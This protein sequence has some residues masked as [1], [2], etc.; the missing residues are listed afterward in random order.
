MDARGCRPPG[1]REEE[2]RDGRRN[3]AL[4]TRSNTPQQVFRLQISCDSSLEYLSPWNRQFVTERTETRH[5]HTEGCW[6]SKTSLTGR[7][8]PPGRPFP[9]RAQL[10]WPA[11]RPAVCV[12]RSGG[13]RPAGSAWLSTNRAS[14]VATSASEWI[15]N[16]LSTNPRCHLLN[17]KT[18]RA[19]DVGSLALAATQHRMILFVWRSLFVWRC[20]SSVSAEY[21]HER[22]GHLQTLRNGAERMCSKALTDLPGRAALGAHRAQAQGIVTLGE[23]DAVFI[24]HQRA[25]IKRR[26]RK[27]ERTIEQELAESGQQ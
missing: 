4:L 10:C 2:P 26:R 11:E 18:C 9:R 17:D 27:A 8:G 12:R 21:R 19:A 23:P 6:I 15:C 16:R 24:G 14:V 20:M 25:M 5:E 1:P 22:L 3:E 13:F 7:D